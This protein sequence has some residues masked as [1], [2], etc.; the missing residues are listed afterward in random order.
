[1]RILFIKVMTVLIFMMVVYSLGDFAVAVWTK[2]T[3]V[4]LIK[5]VLTFAWAHLYLI[6]VSLAITGE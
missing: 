4:V 2:S 5:L 6:A 3:L 1:M